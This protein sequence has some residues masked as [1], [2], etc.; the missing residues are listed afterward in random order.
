MTLAA[1]KTVEPSP[2]SQADMEAAQEARR[3]LA[4]LGGKG[5]VRVEA[6]S[7]HEAPQS[8]ILP[9]TE[10]WPKL[11]DAVIRRRSVLACW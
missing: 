1:L 6:A 11:G 3:T 9:T 7:D 8:F 5:C 2:P 4:R 10:L